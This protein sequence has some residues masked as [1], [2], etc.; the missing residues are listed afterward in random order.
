MPIQHQLVHQ[1]APNK[2]SPAGDKNTLPVLVSPELYFWVT[3]GLGKTIISR[4]FPSN[5]SEASNLWYPRLEHGELAFKQFDLLLSLF[6][7][8]LVVLVRSKV[9]SVDL[10][11]KFG[12]LLTKNVGS[13]SSVNL[14]G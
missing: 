6:Q 2:T 10:D 8:V 5:F 3:A 4:W 13:N 9:S 7:L 12:M 1:V 11:K 14:I